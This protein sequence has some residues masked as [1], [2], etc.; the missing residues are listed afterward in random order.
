MAVMKNSNVRFLKIG[1]RACVDIGKFL[2]VS[3]REGEPAALNLNHK[4]VAFFES[5]G[6]VRQTEPDGLGFTW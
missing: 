4:A 5:M 6:D 3:V 1:I 2:R